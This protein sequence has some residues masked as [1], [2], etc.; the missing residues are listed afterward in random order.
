MSFDFIG[1]DNHF[2]Y[3]VLKGGRLFD[4]S[5]NLDRIGDLFIGQGKILWWREGAVPNNIPGNSAKFHILD[6]SGLTITPG[7]IDLHCHLR[8]PG[9]EDKETIASGTM[10][11]AKG[12]FTTIC[13]MPNTNPPIDSAAIVEYIYK[14]AAEVSPIRVLPIGCISKGR[15]GEKLAEM[16][17]L[18]EAGV[19]GYSDDGNPLMNS[20]LMLNV[21]EYS[22]PF[23]L[24]VIDHCEDLN[25]STGGVMNEGKIA[26]I[27][28]LKGIP[29]A[30]E[31]IMVARDIALAE[32]SKARLHLA[33][34]STA[35][36]LELIKRAKQKGLAV[37]CEVTPHHL[38]LTEELIKGYNANAKVNPPLRT[39]QDV[40]ALCEGLEAG[41]IDAIATDHAP[42][43]LEDKLCE[44]DSAASGI[45]GFETAL[46]CLLTLAKG[47]SFKTIISGLTSRP[48]EI[49]CPQGNN[50]RLTLKVPSLIGTL[51]IG[52][53]ADIAVFDT[54]KCW[55]V[56]TSEFV[57]R[58][59][60][61]PLGG[62]TLKGKVVATFAGGR[63]AY[64]GEPER[65]K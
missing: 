60:N 1:M 3:F 39:M 50:P 32:I 52:A 54:E 23:G 17:E 21:M 37:S 22:K 5:Q 53:P 51:V 18:Y 15:K 35:G 19:V 48:A 34:I 36:S 43:T 11:A 31:E 9:F 10:A 64:M 65:L 45:S 26:N 2:E 33:H 57:S 41:L 16:G 58:G 4:P 13:C 25:L 20:S 56:D 49:I 24:P 6:A 55:N 27:M 61:T 62:M 42:H 30:A 8:E 28:G 46:A 63:I 12:G 59:R 29:S 47:V 14:K 38:S 44:F 40:R 7:F